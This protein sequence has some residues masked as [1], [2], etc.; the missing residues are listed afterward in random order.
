ILYNCTMCAHHCSH[1]V[2]FYDT[3]TSSIYTLSLHDALPILSVVLGIVLFIVAIPAALSESI[4]ADVILFNKNIF[5]ATD[6]LVS[7]I[8]LPFGSLCIA[9]FIIHRVNKNFVK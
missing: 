9:I 6:Y 4:L 5:D 8:M 2:F 1:F 3:A 7:N